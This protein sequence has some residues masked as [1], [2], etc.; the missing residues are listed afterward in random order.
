MKRK[1]VVLRTFALVVLA[2]GV[3]LATALSRQP[4]RPR[5]FAGLR[6]TRSNRTF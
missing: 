6:S 4:I 3:A 5:Y 1:K 2:G